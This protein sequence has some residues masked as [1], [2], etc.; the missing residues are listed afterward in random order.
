V[1]VWSK[2][3]SLNIFFKIVPIVKKTKDTLRKNGTMAQ[4]HNGAM[5]QLNPEVKVEVE[6]SHMK[7]HLI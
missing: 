2:K 4:W 7:S 5:E 6:V 1:R 3:N